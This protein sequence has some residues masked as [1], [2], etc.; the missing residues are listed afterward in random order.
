MRAKGSGM[1]E[2]GGERKRGRND[3]EGRRGG[4]SMNG[5]VTM[6]FEG[7]KGLIHKDV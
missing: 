2:K 7:R 3:R 1:K 4:G 5:Y 6:V